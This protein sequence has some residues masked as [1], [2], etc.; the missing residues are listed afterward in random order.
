MCVLEEVS[1]GCGEGVVVVNFKNLRILWTVVELL[2]TFGSSM[3]VAVH[4][5]SV[6]RGLECSQMR[7]SLRNCLSVT[8]NYVSSFISRISKLSVN[9]VIEVLFIRKEDLEE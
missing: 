9:L 8:G 7:M 4:G 6:N 2:F 1:P 5:V 3:S